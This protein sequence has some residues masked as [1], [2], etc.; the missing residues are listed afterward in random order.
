MAN[1][2]ESG[3]GRHHSAMGGAQGGAA[4]GLRSGRAD[5]VTEGRQ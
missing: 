5:L 3:A 4:A 1:A 2:A